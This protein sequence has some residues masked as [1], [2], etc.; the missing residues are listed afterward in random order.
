MRALQ[1]YRGTPLVPL[2]PLPKSSLPC[3]SSR[4]GRVKILLEIRNCLIA[5]AHHFLD[6]TA[7]NSFMQIMN[8]FNQKCIFKRKKKT[9]F[10]RITQVYLSQ[11]VH[12]AARFQIQAKLQALAYLKKYSYL[13]FFFF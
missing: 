7:S 4:P 6:H 5:P 10:K 1:Y 2:L 13:F 9:P 3:Y 11:E 12:N 8:F